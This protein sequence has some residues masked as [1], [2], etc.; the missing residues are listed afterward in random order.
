MS[1]SAEKFRRVEHFSVSLI[2]GIEKL[3]ASEVYVTIFDFLS[4]NFRL[5]VLNCFVDEPL[6]AVFQKVSGSEKVYERRRR[7]VSS[8][9]VEVFLSH[10]AE[11][12]RG[13]TI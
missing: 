5:T 1:H 12:F 10:C 2:S 3:Y 9:A 4:K 8:L 11:N 7:G 6:C 13:G